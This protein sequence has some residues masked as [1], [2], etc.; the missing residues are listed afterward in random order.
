MRIS[1]VIKKLQEA[2]FEL[3]D[4]ILGSAGQY[5]VTRIINAVIDEERITRDISAS[6]LLVC[7]LAE[8]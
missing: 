1:E 8:S 7:L 6:P 3:G 2:E 5:Q 4:F